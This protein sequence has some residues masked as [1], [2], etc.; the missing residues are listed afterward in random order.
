MSVKENILTLLRMYSDGSY[1]TG[2]FCEQFC[3]LYFFENDG[4]SFFSGA[5]RDVLDAFAAVAERYSDIEE[6]LRESPGT[7]KDEESVKSAFQ[8]V[9]EAFSL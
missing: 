4:R 7:Y 3:T 9:R 1:R 5:D 6:D 8:K 2:D